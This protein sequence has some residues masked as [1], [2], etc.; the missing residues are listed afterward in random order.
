MIATIDTDA[1]YEL[2]KLIVAWSLIT[3][4][5]LT[6]ILTVLSLVGWVKF[7]NKSQQNKL[8]YVLIVQLAIGCVGFV[9]GKLVANPDAV[10]A[11]I[12]QPLKEQTQQAL[13]KNKSLEEEK[14]TLTLALND[15]T[16]KLEMLVA[17]PTKAPASDERI[18]SLQTELEDKQKNLL[19][20]KAIVETLEAKSRDL[21]AA[22]TKQQ[23]EYEL[24][25]GKGSQNR[26]KAT[27]AA[28]KDGKSKSSVAPG[29]P[30]PT[31]P[32]QT[33][34]AIPGF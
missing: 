26:M 2:M 27:P 21:E 33:P 18:A 3:A 31:V 13:I 32:P 9:K 17:A 23:L 4:F 6:L 10:K 11:K 20:Y 7:A 28:K 25:R 29:S 12:E 16:R 22:L 5:V 14:Q 34:G 8:F 19:E 24:A 30:A 1:Q 15:S